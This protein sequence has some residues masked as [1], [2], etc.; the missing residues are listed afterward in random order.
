MHMIMHILILFQLANRGSRCDFALFV[1][2]SNNNHKSISELAIRSAGLK[3]YLNETYT[4]LKLDDTMI[5][6]KVRL[7]VPY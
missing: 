1:G 5:W 6:L 4:T 2:A 3:M 7:G